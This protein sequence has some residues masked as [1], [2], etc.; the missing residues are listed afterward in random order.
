MWIIFKIYL[1]TYFIYIYISMNKYYT[2]H[3]GK[4]RVYNRDFLFM[5]IGKI[6]FSRFRKQI[7]YDVHAGQIFGMCVR[8]FNFYNSSNIIKLFIWNNL[9]KFKTI[10]TLKSNCSLIVHN[11]KSFSFFIFIQLILLYLQLILYIDDSIN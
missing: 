9:Q 4:F 7:V 2:V 1:C 11:D 3:Y 6:D 8:H 10:M 5:A